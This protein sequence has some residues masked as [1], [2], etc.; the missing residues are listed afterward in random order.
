MKNEIGFLEFMAGLVVGGSIALTCH[1]GIPNINEVKTFQEENRPAIM[2]LYKTGRDGIM[3]DPEKDGTY[4]TLSKHLG[5][6]NDEAERVIEEARI[7][8]TVG[9]YNK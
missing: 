9:W 5:T 7:K 2:R 3:V 6:I 8:K 1:W 4:V